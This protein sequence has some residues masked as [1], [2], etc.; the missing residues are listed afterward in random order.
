M[1]AGE[2]D[3]AEGVVG[4][5]VDGER[6]VCVCGFG[7]RL[8]VGVGMGGAGRAHLCRCNLRAD[9][10]FRDLILAVDDL[11]SLPPLVMFRTCFSG[12]ISF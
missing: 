4:E 8:H 5:A 11:L 12:K 3:E 9:R 1:G 6:P 10:S 2:G 7:G